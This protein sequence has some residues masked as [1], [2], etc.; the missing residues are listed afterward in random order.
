MSEQRVQHTRSAPC[1]VCNGHSGLPVGKG[2]RCHGY[3]V[4]LDHGT[5]AFCSREEHAGGRLRDSGSGLYP[6]RLDQPCRCG[7]AHGAAVVSIGEASRAIEATYDYTDAEGVLRYQ[8]VRYRPKAFKQRTPDGRGGWTW[9]GPGKSELLIYRLPE[10]IAAVS[11]GDTIYVVEGE[12]D[13]E[14]LRKLGLTATCCSGGAGHWP[15][16][17][18]GYFAGANVV[19]VADKDEPGLEHAR[20]EF[21]GLRPFANSI[22]VVEARKGKDTTDH[23][24]HGFGVSDFV[25]LWPVSDL[26]A[27]DPAAWKRRILRMALDVTEPFKASAIEEVTVRERGP[28]W[29]SGLEGIE[30]PLRLSGVTIVS[31]PP[32]SAKSVLAISSS[33]AAARSGWDVLYLSAEMPEEVIARRIAEHAAG[34]LPET[35]RLVDVSYGATIETLMDFAED[36]VSCRP[37][38]IVFD[39]LSSFV[40]QSEITNEHDTFGMGPLRR[41]VMWAINSRRSSEGQLSFLLLSEINKEGRAKG[42]MADHRADLA[43]SMSL[44]D[45]YHAMKTIYVT[46]GWCA[47]IGLLG[48]FILDV[49]SWRL[50]KA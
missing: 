46:K 7:V 37:T 9:K 10:V 22:R 38:L 48:D 31:G 32:S 41:L 39:S 16:G 1:V 6:H 19:I 26:R 13:V 44:H 30:P 24:G 5:Y 47:P 36:L 4:T 27:S 20:N 50:T 8:V 14:A 34:D 21:R 23:L 42:R 29:P 45:T 11:A 40:D 3:T 35:F 18:S 49:D 28:T 12:K 17:C 2:V 15:N 33:I 43:L 25:P